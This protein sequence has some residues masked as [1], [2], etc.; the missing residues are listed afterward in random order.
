VFDHKLFHSR[1]LVCL[2]DLVDALGGEHHLIVGVSDHSQHGLVESGD[3]RCLCLT[4]LACEQIDPR[5]HLGLLKVVQ[6]AN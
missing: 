3:H 1:V 6:W 5:F 2:A 4:I